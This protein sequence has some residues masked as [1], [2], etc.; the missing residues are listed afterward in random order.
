MNNMFEDYLDDY[1]LVYL[2][3]IVVL[4]KDEEKQ[5]E[6]M[7]KVLTVLREHKLFVQPAKCSFIMKENS[8]LGHLDGATRCAPSTL[9]PQFDELFL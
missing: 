3:D 7:R 9:I 4:S 5:K 1:V 8:Y 6:H 2:V